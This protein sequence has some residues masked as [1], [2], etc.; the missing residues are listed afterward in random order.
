MEF[1]TP[2]NPSPR[3]AMKVLAALFAFVGVAASTGLY[4]D[5]RAPFNYTEA[6]LDTSTGPYLT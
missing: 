6:D 5:G 1:S 2:R 3:T 4:F